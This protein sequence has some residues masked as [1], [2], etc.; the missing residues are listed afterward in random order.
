V[1][2]TTIGGVIGILLGVGGSLALSA[3]FD[4]LPA[5]ITWW[6]PA[7]AFGVSAAVGIF[8]GVVPA[9]RAGRL[10]RSSRCAPSEVRACLPTATSSGLDDVAAGRQAG[11]GTA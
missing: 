11:A 3:A 2:L 1:L 7:M 4:Q 10:T 5:V 6:S 9:R 8:F